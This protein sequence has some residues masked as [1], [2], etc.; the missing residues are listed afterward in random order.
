[1][2]EFFCS[3]S[4]I[5]DKKKIS[6]IFGIVCFIISRKVKTQVKHMKKI[7]AVYGEVL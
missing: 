6:N 3:Y 7:C 4:N 5:E 2:G 1:M